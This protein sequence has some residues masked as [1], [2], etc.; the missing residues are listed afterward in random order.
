MWQKLI[1]ATRDYFSISHR[2]A[3]GALVLMLLSL[4]IIVSTFIIRT[5]PSNSTIQLKKHSFSEESETKSI[6]PEITIK[7]RIFDPNMEKE[8]HT[9]GIPHFLCDR[10]ENY[11]KNGGVFI[12][13]SDLAKIYDFPDTLYTKLEPFI[14]LPTKLIKS[15]TPIY[16]TKENNP[17]PIIE[18]AP[19]II[20]IANADSLE[21]I[22]IKGVGKVIA[23]RIIKYR[24]KLGGF[25][26]K[27][28]LKEVYGISEDY[29][30]TI[31]KQTTLSS[32]EVNQLSLNN[33]SFKNFVHHPYLQYE[34]V[35]KIFE[36]K[37][38]TGGFNQVKDLKRFGVLPD[39]IYQKVSPYLTL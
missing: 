27:N 11:R 1:K 7:L 31:L 4:I 29:I 28:Q 8:L 3:R 12:V 33:D 21:L 22:K 14:D 32:T 18:K 38:T 35:K 16:V 19:V 26:S 39:S 9:L 25:Y 2:E 34:D 23:K 17:K 5:K 15:P 24:D 13:K 37:Q 20:D 6:T 10:I 30:A 36:H